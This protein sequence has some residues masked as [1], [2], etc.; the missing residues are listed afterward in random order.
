MKIKFKNFAEEDMPLFLSWAKKPHVATTWFMEGY[1]NID[2]YHEKIEGNGYDHAFIICLNG[3][4]I[5]YIQSCDLYAYRMKCLILKGVFTQEDPGTFCLD[6]F[7]GEEE[8]LDKGYGTEIVKAFIKKLF[9]DF[10]AK[11]ILIDP[12]CS[13]KRAIRCYEKAGFVVVKKE[14]DGINEC[15]G[16]EF[17]NN[18]I[19]VLNWSNE[20]EGQAL[21]LLNTREDT[22]L[23]LLSNLKTYG[24]VLAKDTYSA[25]FKCLVNNEKVVAV[26]AL[27]K[28]GNLLLQTDRLQDYSNIII[29]E[30]L[31]SPIPLK[32]IVAD[33]VLAKPMWDYAKNHIPQLKE[34][35]HQ[36]EILF[37]LSLDNITKRESKFNI[38]YLNAS[39][40]Q[41][42]HL[43]NNLFLKERGLYQAEDA[44]LKYKRFLKDVGNNYLLGLFIDKK[45]TSMAA[46]TA[47]VNNVGLIGGVYTIPEKRKLGLAKDLIYQLL[48]DGRIIKHLEKIILFT[49]EDNFAA[50]SLYESLGF[51]R[52]GYFGLLFGEYDK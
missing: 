50:I 38:R 23:F 32:G 46:F 34:T 5:G 48:L 47:H 37:K 21:E 16:M 9:K 45:L 51:K 2:K 44:E 26:F 17:M 19:G 3:K 15:Y 42:W 35:A 52:I 6:L 36:K 4:A 49:G 8:Y 31:K 22:S 27:T 12:A 43:L 18:S 20:L 24:T 39:D 11:K 33:W 7:I 10:N 14:H 28:I 41:E 29:G 30:C 40:Y 25:D 1:E 13:N